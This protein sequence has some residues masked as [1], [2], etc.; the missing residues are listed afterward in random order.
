LFDGAVRGVRAVTHPIQ[1]SIVK[2]CTHF[3]RS[4]NLVA[5]AAVRAGFDWA[6]AR[7][8]LDGLPGGRGL[9]IAHEAVDRH[10][11]GSRAARVAL[12]WLGKSG[13]CRDVT[14]RALAAE[15]NRFATALGALG[16]GA[17]GRVFVLL[18][19]EGFEPGVYSQ[20]CRDGANTARSDLIL[21]RTPGTSGAR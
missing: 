18:E 9:N 20:G 13:E 19:R 5:Y 15:T 11:H 16:M 14:Y 12:R 7:A 21:L 2:D 17:G 4:P 8:L 3:R 1:Q 6:E 10:A